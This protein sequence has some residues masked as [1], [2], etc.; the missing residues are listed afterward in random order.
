M[1]TKRARL[2][3]LA[4]AVAGGVVV[5]LSGLVAEAWLRGPAVPPAIA[6]SSAGN[7]FVG[8]G[9]DALK[10]NPGAA[11]PVARRL[12][13]TAFRITLGWEPGQTRLAPVDAAEL[14]RAV[15]SAAGMRL[16]LAVYA[17]GAKAPV[18]S[19]LRD[20]YCEYV[21]STLERHPQ[22]NDVVIWNEPNKSHFWRPQFTADGSSAAP[23]A[24]AALLG[25]CWD[26]LHES[27]AG[28]NVVGPAT[29]PA[30]NDRP[31]AKS[32]VS[33]SPGNFIRKLGQA[34]R[35]SG[36]RL[37]LFDTVGHNV[38][39]E[40]TAERPWK[41]H[42]FSD[43]ISL[44][45]WTE[46]MQALWDAFHGTPQPIPG[47]CAGGRCTSIWYLENGFQTVVDSHK[48]SLYRGV[49][50]E[51][52]P[53]PDFGGGEPAAPRVDDDSPAP[54][55][56][57]QI[58]DAVRLAACQ[59]YVEAYFNFLLVDELDL[60]GWQSGALWADWTPK[61]SFEAFARAVGEAN[62]RTVDCAALKGGRVPGVFRPSVG[63]DVVETQWPKARRFNWRNAV[64]RFR[65][66][67]AED[68]DY[69]AV[70]YRLDGSSART[71]TL[72]ARGELREGFLSFVQFPA[73]RLQPGIYQMQIELVS[74]G[75]PER[76]SVRASPALTVELPRGKRGGTAAAVQAAAPLVSTEL[77]EIPRGPRVS[78]APESPQLG[79]PGVAWPGDIA[80]IAQALSLSEGEELEK[81]ILVE[82]NRV[83]RKHGLRALA[84]S[85]ALARGADAHARSMG[86]RGYFSHDW[87]DGRPF[88]KWILRYYPVGQA[89]IWSAGE[90]LLWSSLPLDPQAAADMWL[91]SPPHRRI[92]LGRQWRQLAIGVVQASS[93]P[94]VYSGQ[95]VAIAVAHFGVRY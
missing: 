1:N 57:T 27:R 46:L 78:A 81:R 48:A 66:K 64:W 41:R 33:H 3:L 53:L 79:F 89:R 43:R 37:P 9:D 59:P 23:P 60:E 24:Y 52:H 94:G 22:I 34:Y 80:S 88:D 58:L 17:T 90:N 38:Y 91:R 63:V 83:R 65:V 68:A 18:T 16:V 15:R 25:R 71:P 12:G 44:G 56:A 77:S 85:S 30:G 51:R 47:E 73:R 95:A 50:N 84:F 14:D 93:A 54:D 39:G 28:V 75:N 35:A 76:K 42:R 45:D 61:D 6:S 4:A 8:F 2:S 74:S 26:V 70:V 7:F 69:Q 36:R 10:F 29:S 21:R 11:V 87:A 19:E 40:T 86:L 62:A 92:L 5:A 20:Q 67:T 32:N 72:R 49:P 82:L 55:Q 13:A 31:D